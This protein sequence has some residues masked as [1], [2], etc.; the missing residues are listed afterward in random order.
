MAKNMSNGEG[1]VEEQQKV[2]E[3]VAQH[4]LQFITTAAEIQNSLSRF[5][6]S[7]TNFPSCSQPPRLP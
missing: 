5:H 1:Y 3:C 4:L 6:F 7:V 2:E